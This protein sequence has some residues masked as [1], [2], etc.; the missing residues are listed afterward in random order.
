M[1]SGPKNAQFVV[2]CG[3]KNDAQ[4]E[5]GAATESVVIEE[6]NSGHLEHPT[7][8]RAPTSSGYLDCHSSF[9][10]SAPTCQRIRASIA[11]MCW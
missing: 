9:L 7:G 8:F 4:D 11:P 5:Q 1:K 2:I 6:R 3:M 10:Q